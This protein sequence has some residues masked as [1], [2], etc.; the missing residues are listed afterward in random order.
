MWNTVYREES[1]IRMEI[2]NRY[3]IL[4]KDKVIGL[5]SLTSSQRTSILLDITSKLHTR[6]WRMIKDQSWT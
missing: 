2:I 4:K 1:E 6:E 3:T 5:V